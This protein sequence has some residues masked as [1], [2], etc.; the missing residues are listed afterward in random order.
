MSDIFVS[1]F[2]GNDSNDGLTLATAKKTIAAGIAITG[3]SDEMFIHPGIYNENFTNT[4]L[5]NYN[6]T[7]VGKV[8]LDGKNLINICFTNNDSTA[9]K[10]KNLEIKNYKIKGIENRASAILTLE[11][12]I[13][14]NCT[15]GIF[16]SST[17]DILASY[18]TIYDC[19]RGINIE[20]SSS[21]LL[22]Q[23]TIYNCQ[24]G[25]RSETST[26]NSLTFINNILSQNDIAI[27]VDDV[28][29]IVLLD[30]NIY[31]V[32][33]GAL[34]GLKTDATLTEYSTFAAWKT[35]TGQDALS[36]ETDPLFANPDRGIFSVL[37]GS[38][39]ESGSLIGEYIGSRRT[40]VGWYNAE[41][42]QS[43]AFLESNDP[44]VF[45]SGVTPGGISGLF[46]APNKASL[47]ETAP[48]DLGQTRNISGI[49]DKFLE[50]TIQ[51]DNDISDNTIT[52]GEVTIL[53][54]T[55]DTL[56]D[57]E[58]TPY[59]DYNMRIPLVSGDFEGRFIQARLGIDSILIILQSI[60]SP[61]APPFP[62]DYDSAD[63]GE[64]QFAFIGRAS[65][66]KVGT[67]LNNGYTIEE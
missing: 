63:A 48:I 28:A 46:L 12:L 23:C 37:P 59:V 5:S 27:R 40:E 13:I 47:V 22:N 49:F 67:E 34:F 52:S 35:A 58:T 36:Q 6:V 3:A 54:R 61:A 66:N 65:D 2:G 11:N 53:F 44:D 14:N 45:T 26:S 55:A 18:V 39:A 64:R 15:I 19:A 62:T 33:S 43:G 30:G 50:Q 57:L 31:D 41:I 29:N 21:G 24:E 56:L 38:P 4:G 8:I 17:S 10:I 20:S 16:G 7:G 32:P 60:I 42:F 25:I 1:K 51:I 9:Y